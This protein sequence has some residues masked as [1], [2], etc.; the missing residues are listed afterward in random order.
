M[1]ITLGFGKKQLNLKVDEKNIL[2]ESL[3]PTLSKVM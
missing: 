3:N 1:N 2:D